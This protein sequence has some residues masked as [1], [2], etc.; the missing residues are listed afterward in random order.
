MESNFFEKTLSFVIY[1]I[2][3]LGGFVEYIFGTL[4]REE[5]LII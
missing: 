3:V 5:V 2:V 1:P 4:E